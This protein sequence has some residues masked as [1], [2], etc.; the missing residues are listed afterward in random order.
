MLLC[1][2]CL[3]LF[4]VCLF[5]HLCTLLPYLVNKDVYKIGGI[6]TPKPLNRLSQNLGWVITLAI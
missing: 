5:V 2:F 6:R 3:Y 1:L 4:F